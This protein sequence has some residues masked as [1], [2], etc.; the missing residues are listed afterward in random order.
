MSEFCGCEV[1]EMFVS[2]YD[3][4]RCVGGTGLARTNDANAIGFDKVRC[5]LWW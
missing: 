1:S 4:W 3:E 2:G 5:V